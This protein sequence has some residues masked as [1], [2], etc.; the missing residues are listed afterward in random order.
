MP[1]YT[2][3]AQELKHSLVTVRSVKPEEGNLYLKFFGSNMIVA[4]ADKRR[5]AQCSVSASSTD[6]ETDYES[7]FFVLPLERRSLFEH[8]TD[9]VTISVSDVIKV[10][11]IENGQSKKATLK[12]RVGSKFSL[13]SC[14]SSPYP[15]IDSGVFNEIL[16]HVSCSASVRE[17]K[18]EEDMKVNQVHFFSE[19]LCASSQ[20]RYHVTH[21]YYSGLLYDFSLVSSDIPIFKSFCDKTSGPINIIHDDKKIFLSG[22]KSF[23]ST[24]RVSIRR[25]QFVSLDRSGFKYELE[26]N[27]EFFKNSF[28]W[29]KVA[30][31]GTNK[32]SIDFKKQTG[33]NGIMDTYYGSDL[34][35]SI[36]I[37]FKNGES[38]QADFPASVFIKISGHMG[39]EPVRMKYSHSSSSNLFEISQTSKNSMETVHM[40]QSMRTK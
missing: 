9:F 40:L 11:A 34:I 35:S 7:D 32:I 27:S 37:L 4:S 39:E 6:A 21:V 36:P 13:I 1:K 28:D 26:V 2:F 17:T 31:E 33:E 29:A 24:S 12:K 16:Q 3:Q 19:H 23:V 10:N 15:S 25:P 8:D 20:S 5:Y 30:I 22:N 38:F 14:P 18:T